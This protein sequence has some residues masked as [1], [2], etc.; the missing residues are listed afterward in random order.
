MCG[1]LVLS[2]AKLQA[3]NGAKEATRGGPSRGTQA[4]QVSK[5]IPFTIG[6]IHFSSSMNEFIGK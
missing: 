1:D 3:E 6:R 2:D 5:T 4:L